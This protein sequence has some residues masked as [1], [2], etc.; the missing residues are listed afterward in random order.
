MRQQL[1]T[2]IFFGGNCAEAM[3]FYENTLGAKLNALMKY[4]EAPDP[5]QCPAGGA[6]KIMHAHLVLEGGSNL[7]AS[8]WAAPKPYPGMSGFSVSLFYPQAADARRAFD[9]LAKG[10]QVMMP[11]GKVFWSEAFGMLVDK[12]GTPWMVSGGAAVNADPGK[13]AH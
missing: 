5:S 9:A 7:M 3:R 1:D 8:D 10:G 6:D 11:L 13:Q 2:Y 4:G 12:F